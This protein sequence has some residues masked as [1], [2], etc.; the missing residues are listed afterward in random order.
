MSYFL[1][2]NNINSPLLIAMTFSVHRGRRNYQSIYPLVSISHVY[3]W[4]PSWVRARKLEDFFPC[5][6]CNSKY[7]IHIF[8]WLSLMLIS[9]KGR[10]WSLPCWQ[11]KQTKKSFKVTYRE[12]ISVLIW[13]SQ[14]SF[15][16]ERLNGYFIYLVK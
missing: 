10:H 13:S 4:G 3:C 16:E 14:S 6:V 11:I 12:E 2:S 8:K 7:E 1:L 5:P 15:S 9:C